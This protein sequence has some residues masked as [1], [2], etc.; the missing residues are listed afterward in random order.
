[1]QTATHWLMPGGVMAL[2]CPETVADEYSDVR[3]H[4]GIYYENCM[5][6]PFPEEHRRFKEVIVFGHKRARPQVD[7]W[8]SDGWDSVQAPQGFIYQ[9]PG[10][11]GPRVFQK[12]EPTETELQHMLARSPLA[13]PPDHA[14]GN[15][16]AIATAGTRHRSCGP[17]AGQRAS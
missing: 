9:I 15:S 11:P 2:V 7:K 4:F 3:R 10:G 6:V 17:S 12:I 13:F 16:A 8:A 14:A 5:I 1:M